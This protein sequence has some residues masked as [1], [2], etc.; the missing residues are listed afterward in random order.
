VD[1]PE[2]HG[3]FEANRRWA[4]HMVE[5][6]PS[7]FADLVDVQRP[8]YLW[9]GCADSR[10]PANEIIGLPPGAVFVHRNVANQVKQ[11]DANCLSVLQYAI[12]VLEVRHVIVT[13]HYG[14]GGVAAALGG[15]LDEPLETWLH[16]L[17]EMAAANA[18][19]I[20]E[21]GTPARRTDR[22]CELNVIAQVEAVCATQ[23]ARGAWARGQFLAV[24]GWIYGLHDGLLRDLHV[25]RTAP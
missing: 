6:T 9:I 13:G 24:H 15:A 4:R 18:T 5:A 21:L 11:G 8:R 2:L 25:T 17:R 7:F 10:V 19:E 23:F 12:D 20:E 22:L 1:D 16:D 14:C 3:L